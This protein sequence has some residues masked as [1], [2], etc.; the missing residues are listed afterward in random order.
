MTVFPRLL[1]AALGATVLMVTFLI[2]TGVPILTSLAL[3]A[4]VLWQA[5]A[6]VII[7]RFL[8][9]D[10]SWLEQAGAGVALGTALATIAG[11]GTSTLGLGPFGALV[12]SLV[13]VGVAGIRAERRGHQFRVETR[14]DRPAL[15]GLALTLLSGLAV[16]LYS[17]RSYPLSWQGSWL[18]YHP[19][20]LFFEA[21][22]NSL[23]RFGGLESPFMS[24]GVVRYHWLSYAWSGQLSVLSGAEPFVGIT[25]VLPLV[26]LI[27]S[28]AIVITWTRRLSSFSWTPTLA[29]VLLTLGGF[30]GAVFGGVLT[31]DS[32]SQAMGVLWLLGFALVAVEVTLRTAHTRWALVLLF[33][34]S[35]VLIGGKVSAAAPAVAGVLLMVTVLVLR[36]AISPRRALAIAGVTTLGAAVG[37]LLFL[38]GSVGGGG[39]TLGS[40]VDR[41]S[42]QQGFNPLDGNRGVILG[43]ALIILAVLPRWAGLLWLTVDR[44]W[45]W[46]PETWL[47]MGMAI[48][49]VA[50]LA[51]FNS[52]NEIWFSSTVS[53]PLAITTSVGAGLALNTL[54]QR[55]RP[56][57]TALLLTT[58]A[59]TLVTFLLISAVWATGASGGNLFVPTWRWLGPVLAWLGAIAVG[60]VLARWGQGRWTSLGVLAG[61]VLLLVFSAV[62]GRFVGFGTDQAGILTNGMRIEWFSHNRTD[63]VQGRDREIVADLSSSRVEAARWLRRTAKPT[64]LVATN[65]TVGPF[66][67][68]FTHLP[69]YVSGILYQAPYGPPWVTPEL[70]EREAQAWDFIDSPQNETQR[71]LCRA[72]VSWIWI[73]THRTENRDWQSFG[74]IEFRNDD[75]IVLRL[76]PNRCSEI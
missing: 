75:V 71:P 76:D 72:N 19:D 11:L 5:V 62:P 24:G 17:L 53:G 16:L 14:T 20:M 21:L 28:A 8:R 70:L 7:W 67:A 1:S 74:T 73:D 27:A 55:I 50:A 3:A 54:H 6:G 12:P 38:S 47:S 59:A 41:A 31:M 22:A 10:S 49:S 61:T 33:L 34:L 60:A 56:S 63:W 42:S 30:T 35:L 51:V 64:D 26:T 68:G 52:F 18:R 48:S 40:L 43:T 37:F 4:L 13:V 65:V 69:T 29:G 58:A 23:A 66:V 15:I 57:D 44:S 32:P 9:P 36:Q 2:V 46:R 45:R 25:R 39:L